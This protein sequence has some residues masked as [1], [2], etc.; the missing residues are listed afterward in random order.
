MPFRS[1]IRP[2]FS[3]MALDKIFPE[4]RRRLRGVYGLLRLDT[5]G[6]KRKWTWIYIGQGFI[7]NRLN[8]Y[9]SGGD[10]CIAEESPTHWVFDGIGVT[11]NKGVLEK[12][13]VEKEM[14][15]REEAL[16]KEYKP[17]CNEHWT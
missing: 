8:L 7:Y 1:K 15:K 2:S 6:G 16:V 11:D 3:Q 17:I 10:E 5:Q 13:R 14:D 9:L 12:M 4:S